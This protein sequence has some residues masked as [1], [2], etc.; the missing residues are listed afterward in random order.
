VR[1]TP[2]AADGRGW[3]IKA[4]AAG[5]QDATDAPFELK[6]GESITDALVVFSDRPAEITGTLQDASGR[7]AT[8]YF[9]ILLP[10]DPAKWRSPNRRVQQVRQRAW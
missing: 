3:F 5:G 8:D 1:A 7:A 4:V 2:A 9:V 6:A 10:A